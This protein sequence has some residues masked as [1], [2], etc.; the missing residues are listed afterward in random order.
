MVATVFVFGLLVLFHELGHF[1]TAKA[2]GMRVEEFAIGFGKKI[3]GMQRG[4]TLYS[5]RLI[6]LGGFNKISGMDPDEETDERSY[7][8]KP[9]WARMV[10][11]VAGSMMNFLLP[12]ALFFIV[13][14]SS[15]ISTPSTAPILGELLANKP[16]V[17]AWLLPGD[18]IVLING[19]QVA[20][21]NE[22]VA[23]VKTGDREL[24][25][26]FERDGKRQETIVNAEWDEQGKRNVIGALP[27]IDQRE[28][29]AGEALVL[30][31]KQTADV[32]QRMIVGLVQMVTGRAEADLAGPVGVAQM[33]GEV[34]AMG[35]IPLLNFTAF[36]SIN[37]GIINLLPIPALD[38][39]HFV[40][41]VI[42]AIRG[43][44]L[45]TGWTQRIQ[46]IGIALLL[47][48]M[49]FATFKDVTRIL[50]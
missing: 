30:A 41:L 32:F 20:T 31:V 36:L 49:V 4:E 7:C 47:T 18:K 11:I 1:I 27:V 43:K 5:L 16:A 26:V 14:F 12:I 37:L 8:K 34:A 44:A 39:G 3:I 45:D 28:L 9:I 50:F 6:P 23:T 17:T 46:L 48:L 40:S 38:G 2:V 22:L 21:W 10:V 35:I 42:E 24:H 13:L 25:F 29:G 19:Q 33:A 15:G